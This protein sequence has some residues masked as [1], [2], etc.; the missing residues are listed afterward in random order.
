VLALV[1]C[2]IDYQPCLLSLGGQSSWARPALP[3]TQTERVP[4]EEL[5]GQRGRECSAGHTQAMYRERARG[6]R[7]GK[8]SW[9]NRHH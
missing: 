3:R 7:I 9:N 2:F 5:R 4:A 1:L 6:Q 8:L